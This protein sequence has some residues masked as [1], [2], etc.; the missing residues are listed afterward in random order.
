MIV[1]AT[2]SP[3]LTNPPPTTPAITPL[4]A[5][6]LPTGP[7]TGPAIVSPRTDS[8]TFPLFNPAVEPI[9]PPTRGALGLWPG[10]AARRS[11]PRRDPHTQ[12][13]TERRGRLIGWLAIAGCLLIVAVAVL[14]QFVSERWWLSTALVYL[15]R[16][17]W[18]V[19]SLILLG[20]TLLFRQRAAG[21]AIIGVLIAAGPLM[22]FRWSQAVPVSASSDRNAVRIVTCN[23]QAF[24][25]DF[26]TQINEIAAA[27]PS[28]VVFQEAFQDHPR[29]QT[30]FREWQEVRIE[31]YY[32]ASRHPLKLVGQ[33]ISPTFDRLAGIAVQVDDPAGKYLMVN[34]HLSTARYGLMN[35]LPGSLIRGG[36]SKLESHVLEREAEALAVRDWIESLGD[37]LP[38]V[39]AGDFNMPVDSHIFHD[40]FGDYT[41]AFETAGWGYG[42]T[43]PCQTKSWPRHCPWARVDHILCDA[44]W[45]VRSCLVGTENGSDHRLVAAVLE[46]R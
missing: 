45:S 44:R 33:V 18:L 39:L 37:E 13:R 36:I 15:P 40:S 24:R 22:G 34:I 3:A 25:P 42:Y 21:V 19:G 41:N 1:P 20:L 4:L 8:N 17:P 38:I 46:R 28:V 12:A 7:V 6:S 2:I 30:F 9:Q 23:V 11:A 35:L 10:T 29:R 32:V 43:A 5:S 14:I 26:P 27:N 16:L 31:E